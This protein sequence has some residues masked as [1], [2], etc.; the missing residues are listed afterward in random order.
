MLFQPLERN[1]WLAVGQPEPGS[2]PQAPGPAGCFDERPEPQRQ[3]RVVTGLGPAQI[4]QN[5]AC[6]QAT[7]VKAEVDPQCAGTDNE[8]V[9]SR[10]FRHVYH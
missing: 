3:L 2:A 4:H 1:A 8:Q 7:G 9:R 10:N 6:T 5:N